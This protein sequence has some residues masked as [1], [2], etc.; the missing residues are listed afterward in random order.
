MITNGWKRGITPLCRGMTQDCRRL[1][2]KSK[3]SV[4]TLRVH[5]KALKLR[6]LN[7]ELS[8]TASF[9]FAHILSPS[10]IPPKKTKH[11]KK[12]ERT[13]VAGANSGHIA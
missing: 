1:L 11:Q 4:M 12:K 2:H 7:V 3:L 13:L 8:L 10:Y 5:R 9:L 6:L